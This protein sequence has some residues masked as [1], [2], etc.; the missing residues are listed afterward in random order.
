MEMRAGGGCRL[1]LLFVQMKQRRHKGSMTIERGLFSTAYT[2]LIESP[3]CGLLTGME[4]PSPMTVIKI[5]FYLQTTEPVL[6]GFWA[7][8]SLGGLTS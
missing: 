5:T 4:P 1:S 6:T 8:G 2:S 3:K 7:Q